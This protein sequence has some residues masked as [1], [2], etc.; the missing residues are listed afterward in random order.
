MAV[1]DLNDW[2]RRLHRVTS[3]MALHWCR[4]TSAELARWG[5][6]LQAIADDM[7]AKANAPLAPVDQAAPRETGDPRA[8]HENH[9]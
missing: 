7:A 4:A 3:S 9:Q 8:A 6:E 2:H 1:I 5:R